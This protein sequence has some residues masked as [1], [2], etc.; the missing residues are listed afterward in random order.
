M[1]KIVL[2]AALI[3]ALHLP[4]QAKSSCPDLPAGSALHWRHDS[5]PGYDVCYALRT[6]GTVAFGLYL[7]T[8]NPLS[9][10]KLSPLQPGIA[11][12]K[13]VMWSVARGSATR[14][15][16]LVLNERTGYK[17][18]VF[19]PGVPADTLQQRMNTVGA[20]RL[21]SAGAP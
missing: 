19:V 1:K 7:G 6:S 20:L 13:P 21:V 5:G 10:S 4:V 9:H 18:H 16:L 2:A 12:G 3:A 15:A 11:A 17:M 8:D 14:H